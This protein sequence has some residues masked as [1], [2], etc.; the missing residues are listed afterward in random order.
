MRIVRWAR[1]RAMVAA[2]CCV[3]LSLPFAGP[4]RADETVEWS[5]Q[6]YA[7]YPPFCRAKLTNGPPAEID[8]WSKQ[9]GR[10]NFM[11]IHHY[12]FGLK[13]MSLAYASYSDKKARSYYARSVVTNMKYILSNTKPDFYLRADTL[14]NLGRGYQLWNDGDKARAAFEQALKLKPDAVDAWVALSDLFYDHGQR[15]QALKVL[16]DAR[17]HAGDHRKIMLRIEQMQKKK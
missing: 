17:T 4:A 16:E 15:E 9:M 6:D 12:C 10:D 8:R 1:L 13:A 11:H 14:I 7:L 2:L 5:E 3:A